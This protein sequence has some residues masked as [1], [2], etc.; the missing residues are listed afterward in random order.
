MTVGVAQDEHERPVGVERRQRISLVQP[1]RLRAEELAEPVV[2][3]AG[4]DRRLG[5]EL[6][7][8]AGLRPSGRIA[9]DAQRAPRGLGA[10]LAIVDAASETRPTPP[11]RDPPGRLEQ[12]L[13]GEA[14]L[15]HRL[16]RSPPEVLDLRRRPVRAEAER[17][18]PGSERADGRL[19]R[20]RPCR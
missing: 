9:L 11:A 12:P 16:R 8:D 6:D 13:L 5:P 1:D 20:S 7:H 15:A 2:G 19:P 4:G 14:P 3:L 10:R 17:V 18:G